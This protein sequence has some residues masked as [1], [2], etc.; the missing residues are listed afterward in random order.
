MAAVG[1][2]QGA[3]QPQKQAAQSRP[4]AQ[5]G[6]A[7]KKEKK[8]SKPMADMT[9]DEERRNE[10]ARVRTVSMLAKKAAKK[11][12]AAG[13]SAAELAGLPQLPFSFDA[14]TVTSKDVR[15]PCSAP[16]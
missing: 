4:V 8:P 16:A 10:A 3:P 14:I 9:P 1:S 12:E 13:P 2:T 15:P 11:R 7:R 6:V 5:Q